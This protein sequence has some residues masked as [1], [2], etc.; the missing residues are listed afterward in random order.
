V[1]GRAGGA[2]EREV[3]LAVPDDFG[4][5]GLS[6]L[7][8]VVVVD[9]GEVRL[10]AVYWDSDDLA[11]CRAGVGLRHRNGVWA[12][13]GG[14]RRDGDAVVREEVEL[15]AGGEEI[16]PAMRGRVQQ[17]VD[18]TALHPVAELDTLRHQLD[19]VDAPQRAEVVH[20]RVRIRDGGRVISTFAEVEV[21]FER[22]SKALADRLVALLVG[23]GAAVEG[24]SK[25]LRALRALGHDP[26]EVW[27]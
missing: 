22:G 20:D 24:T 25:Y 7:A 21:E 23:R 16:P 10:R 26:P 8:G 17:W 5:S 11:L 15:P 4:L 19:V 2:E 1:T 9:R 12:F 3:K 13:K 27:R 6:D 14:S 18:V